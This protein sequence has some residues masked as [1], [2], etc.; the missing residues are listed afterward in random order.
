MPTTVTEF[1]QSRGVRIEQGRKIGR[2]TYM[3]YGAVDSNAAL[4]AG[5]LPALGESFPGEPMLVASDFDANTVEGNS[6]LVKVDIDYPQSESGELDTPEDT[7]GLVTLEVDTDAELDQDA[8]RTDP[9]LLIPQGGFISNDN[10]TDIQGIYADIAGEPVSFKR[11]VGTIVI[12]ENILLAALP[13]ST[14]VTTVGKRNN[15]VFYDFA[16]GSVLHR[17]SQVAASFKNGKARVT[18]RF[19]YDQYFFLKQYPNVNESGVVQ[20]TKVGG[21]MHAASVFWRQPYTVA[22]DLKIVGVYF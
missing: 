8:W 16:P 19:L 13:L 12:A 6:D 20:L 11:Y 10:E 1:I 7:L 18:H 9:G 5:G 2:R 15:V 22:V 17:G 3:V 21:I 14:I 4:Q